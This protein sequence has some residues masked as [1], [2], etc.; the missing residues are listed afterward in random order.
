MVTKNSKRTEQR[1]VGKHMAR[2]SINRMWRHGAALVPLTLV[3]AGWTA[4]LLSTGT[5]SAAGEPGDLS[6]GVSMP[7]EAIRPPASVS[8]LRRFAPTS[9]ARG[10][11]AIVAAASTSAIPATALAAYQRAA[12]VI[13]AADKD[14][15]LGWPLVAAIGRVESDHGRHGDSALDPNGVA[16]PA[17]YGLPLDG[18]AGTSKIED[19]DAGLY[20]KDP[21]FDR[22]VGPMQFIPTTWSLVGVDA[23]GDGRRNPQDI[24]DA[25]LAGAVYLCSGREDLST[26]RGQ[27]AAIFRYNHS[28]AYVRL[29]RSIAADYASGD[30][31]GT[32][33][34]API[35]F[36]Y[37]SVTTIGHGQG[38]GQH[39]SIPQ[40]GGTS[41]T[42][43]PASPQSGQ[44]SAEP[45]QEPDKAVAPAHDFVGDTITALDK[46]TTY[47]RTRLSAAD[48]AL[49]GGV[50]ACATALLEDGTSSIVGSESAVGNLVTGLLGQ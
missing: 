25:A 24:D 17:I 16:K 33:T 20:D 30:F 35:R 41:G 39:A 38:Q 49:A 13:N 48:L 40:S 14:C 3:S 10:A 44:P 12:Q 19:T 6:P 5:S 34:Y 37:D 27:T 9:S 42:Q 11:G 23:D 1:M 36:G 47:C 2:S 46:A 21:V 43:Q 50:K 22:A 26:D 18:R 7:A 4:S 29:V 32:M 31:T 15:R 8:S 28:R 45:A